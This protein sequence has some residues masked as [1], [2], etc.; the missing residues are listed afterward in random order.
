MLVIAEISNQIQRWYLPYDKASYNAFVA[1]DIPYTHSGKHV[2]VSTSEENPDSTHANTNIS[3][4]H[5]SGESV[6]PS[7][8]KEVADIQSSIKIDW[9]GKGMVMMT[10]YKVADIPIHA[11]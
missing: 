3:T 7:A 6:S 1:L 4:T 9:T 10:P 8:G 11:P 2:E 5:H